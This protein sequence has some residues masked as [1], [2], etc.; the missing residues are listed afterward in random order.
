M[1]TVHFPRQQIILRA[2]PSA[3]ELNP[4]RTLIVGQLTTGSATPGALVSNLQ[5]NG[6][7][8]AL[9][10]ADSMVA[11]MV[12][13][14]KRFNMLSQLDVIPLVDGGGA[15]DATGTVVFGGVATASG[16]ITVN[17][18]SRDNHS[19]SLAV[20][21]GDT[22]TVIG[23]ALVT[24]IV[25][26]T[27]APVTG[28]NVT[29]TVTLTAVNG[30][31]VANSIGIEVDGAVAGV[32]LAATAMTGGA[33][34]PVLTGVFDVVGNVR[35]QTVVAP[36][37]YGTSFLTDFLDPRFNPVTIPNILD[38]VGIITSTDTFVNLEALANAENSQS[39]VIEGNKFIDNSLY[40]GSALFEL[41]YVISSILGGIRSVR[42]TT[43]ANISALVVSQNAGEDAIG[44][45][46][47]ASLPYANTPVAG[48]PV[49]DQDKEWTDTEV[50]AL[51]AAGISL[52]GN[53]RTRNS[54]I[55]D[56]VV[57]TRKTDAAGNSEIT[58]KFLNGVDTASVFREFFFES[59]RARF[60]QDRLTD[61]DLVQTRSM[62]N[63]ES[64]RGAQLGFYQSLQGVIAQAGA[65]STDIF[66]STLVISPDVNSGLVSIQMQPILVGQ[67]RAI[68][69]V[70]TVTF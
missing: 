27:R 26:D 35:Y 42:L 36:S 55:L 56:Q 45:P 63:A 8:D 25:A 31:T 29:G 52:M 4:Q 65:A 20:T 54:I 1:S 28:V 24:A 7:E 53:N 67:L 17:I 39:L 12:R 57:T 33:T 64:I 32:T 43:G 2:G 16:T 44:G 9:F 46:Q 13:G 11:A 19:F 69:T 50:V 48:L 10:G 47:I 18:G 15:T 58:F 21:T 59:N 66:L 14:F 23:D 22:A 68:D 30:G 38:G 6:S 40:R 61:G 5:N 62:D 41:N 49:I 60:A 34:D 37:E 51:R 70:I 3:V